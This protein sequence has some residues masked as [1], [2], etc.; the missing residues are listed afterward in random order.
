MLG[1]WVTRFA[2]THPTKCPHENSRDLITTGTTPGGDKSSPTSTK[3]SS[4]SCTPSIET[5]SPAS[6]SSWRRNWPKVLPTSP[7]IISSSG[8][9]RLPSGA[10][11]ADRGGER[12]RVEV[13][14]EIEAGMHHRHVVHRQHAGVRQEDGLAA[15]LHG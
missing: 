11:G 9:L 13:A 6:S 15:H 3:S 7:S 2:L 12:R 14:A 5:R 4:C 8:S 10:T 1:R